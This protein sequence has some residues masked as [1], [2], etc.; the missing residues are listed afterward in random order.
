M[1]RPPK[2]AAPGGDNTPTGPL[3]PGADPEFRVERLPFSAIKVDPEVQPRE[4][5]PSGAEA[6]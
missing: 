6:P 2:T 1:A 4:Q 5:H 3:K